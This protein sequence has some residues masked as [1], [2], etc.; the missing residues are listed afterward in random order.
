MWPLVLYAAHAAPATLNQASAVT[1]ATFTGL[2]AFVLMTGKDFS[3][4]RGILYWG[5]AI[6]LVAA[7]L[8]LGHFPDRRGRYFPPQARRQHG[9]GS[10]RRPLQ[11]PEVR[12]EARP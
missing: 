9:P 6:A 5:F 11:R 10:A 2:T 4:L 1:A 7:R 12:Q 8:F 3:F